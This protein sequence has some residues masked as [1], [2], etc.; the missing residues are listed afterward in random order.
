VTDLNARLDTIAARA[1]TPV[2]LPHGIAS[3]IS[4]LVAA[5]RAV[6]ADCDQIDSGK[7]FERGHCSG[8]DMAILLAANFRDTIAAALTEEPSP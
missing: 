4:A 2:W 5:L 8:C 1:D 6:L 3:D 7:R